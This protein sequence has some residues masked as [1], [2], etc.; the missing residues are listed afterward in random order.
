MVEENVSEIPILYD[1]SHAEKSANEH[2]ADDAP[3]FSR[4]HN[5][6]ALRAAILGVSSQRIPQRKAITTKVT[7][8]VSCFEMHLEGLLD[9]RLR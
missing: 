7:A 2:L 6:E 8:M 1:R 5:F 3:V 9:Q 4:K